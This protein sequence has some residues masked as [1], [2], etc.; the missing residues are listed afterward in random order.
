MLV[1]HYQET[2]RSISSEWKYE[3]SSHKHW[4][5]FELNGSWWNLKSVEC[6]HN[7]A[8]KQR[9]VKEIISN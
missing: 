9:N 2:D 7:P 5:Q 6:G 4:N 8:P 3:T 1:K